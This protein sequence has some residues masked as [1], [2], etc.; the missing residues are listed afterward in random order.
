VSLHVQ[1]QVITASKSSVTQMTFEGFAARVFAMMSGELVRS[2]ELPVT[3]LPAA[4]VG[5]LPS[6]GPLVGLEVRA[7][8]VNLVAVGVVALVCPPVEETLDQ[9]LT[10]ISFKP[11]YHSENM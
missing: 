5:L 1:A 7:L 4:Q 8:G 10:L 2:G 9:S 6:V 3:S 11:C